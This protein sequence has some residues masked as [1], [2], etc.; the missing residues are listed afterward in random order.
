MLSKVF[1]T[2]RKGTY[3]YPIRTI[4]EMNRELYDWAVINLAK[5]HP[6]LFSEL[7]PKLEEVYLTGIKLAKKLIEY[8]IDRPDNEMTDMEANIKTRLKRTQLVQELHRLNEN[9]EKC[10]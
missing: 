4:C 9:L 3:V 7:L 10:E 5:D 8:N 1:D 6:D 2:T